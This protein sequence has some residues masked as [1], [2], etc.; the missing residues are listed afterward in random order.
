[1]DTLTVHPIVFIVSGPSGSGKGTLMR[2]V[3]TAI[4]EVRHIPTYT[5][6][7][8]RPEE[9]DGE[10][11]N[12]I[13]MEAFE[14]LQASGD[15][16]EATRTYGKHL[17]GSPRSLVDDVLGENLIVELDY[18]GMLRVRARSSLRVVSL[19]ILPQSKGERQK[20]INRRHKESD[21]DARLELASE[22]LQFAWAYDYVL[23][24]ETLESFLAE[25]SAIVRA[26]LL[27]RSGARF[28]LEHMHDHDQTLRDS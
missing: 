28:L 19:F 13:S 24:N 15:I 6:R 14:E 23:R 4:P 25:A 27:R 7:A 26:E 5:T 3:S 20:R 2:H 9:V 21:V 22:Q 18:K 16:F 1:M 10:D 17:Y 11:Y 8:R 12:F